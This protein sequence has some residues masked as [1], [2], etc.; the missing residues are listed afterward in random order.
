MNPAINASIDSGTHVF[1]IQCASLTG[2]DADPAPALGVSVL[3]WRPLRFDE[4]QA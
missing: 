2:G 4:G 1:I 3:A